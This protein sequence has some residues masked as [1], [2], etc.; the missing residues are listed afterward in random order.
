MFDPH[1][2]KRL[3]TLL[4]SRLSLFFWQKPVSHFL[5]QFFSHIKLQ[6]CVESQY[7]QLFIL[8]AVRLKKN[9]SGLRHCKNKLNT[10]I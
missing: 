6:Q 10:N 4:S 8:S 9:L 2:E 1:L 5:P 3:Q 7:A